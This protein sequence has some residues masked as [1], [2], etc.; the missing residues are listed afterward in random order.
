MSRDTF[1]QIRLFRTPSNLALPGFGHP[2][3]P[4][5]S[6]QPVPYRHPYKWMGLSK[7]LVSPGCHPADVA[8]GCEGEKKP[9][10]QKGHV[11]ELQN[12][13]AKEHSHACPEIATAAQAL[14][15]HAVVILA[16]VWVTVIII[17]CA[18]G[19]YYLLF[20]L[21]C[22][23]NSQIGIG[24]AASLVQLLSIPNLGTK[25]GRKMAWPVWRPRT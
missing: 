20:F 24:E 2:Q 10:K 25:E 21:K 17:V 15:N 1:Y 6:A 13:I 11:R 4:W 16:F 7:A 5:A 14:L 23:I 8:T 22:K 19:F 18:V 3:F 12:G 9:Q